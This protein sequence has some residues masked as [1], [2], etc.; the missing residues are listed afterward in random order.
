[1]RS[2]APVASSTNLWQS[3]VRFWPIADISEQLI[4]DVRQ[5][6]NAEAK[7]LL[8]AR[9]SEQKDPAWID[10]TLA[11]L[12]APALAVLAV[13]AE[14]PSILD[15]HELDGWL[16]VRFGLDERER[17]LGIL[18][19]I[20]EVLVV[21]LQTHYSSA[22]ALVTP[23]SEHVV[24]RVLGIDCPPL[25]DAPFEPTPGHDGGRALVATCALLAQVEVRATKDG[26]PHRGGTKRLAKQVAL[27]ESALDRLIIDGLRLGIIEVTDDSVLRVHREALAAAAS[28][29]YPRHALLQG[30][31]TSLRERGPCSANVVDRWA[32]AASV[33]GYAFLEPTMLDRVPGVV[34]GLVGGARAYQVAAPGPNAP[35]VSITPSFEV[36]VPPEAPL[37]DVVKVL[38]VCEPVRLD[39]VIVARLTK[40]SIA[41]A[42]AAGCI[43]VLAV[44]AAVARTPVPQNVAAAVQDWTAGQTTATI[45]HGQV[46]V[47]AAAEEARAAAA[48]SAFRP[49]VLAPGVLVVEAKE[50][51]RAVAAALSK[52]GLVP[53]S[54]LSAR[55]AEKPAQSKE[56]D[57]SSRGAPPL[58]MIAR[59]DLAARVAAYRAGD[60]AERAR[61]PAMKPSGRAAR[62]PARSH[63]GLEDRSFDPAVERMLFAWEDRHELL[64]FEIFD[65]VAECLEALT[66]VDRRFI[67][68]GTTADELVERVAKLAARSAAAKGAASAQLTW[69]RD[70]LLAHL[71]A[72]ARTH[73]SYVF[74]LGGRMQQLKIASVT[75]R[76]NTLMVLG[77]DED[78]RSVAIRFDTIR[79]LAEPAPA[80]PPERAR[81]RPVDGEPP[82][83][84]H[85]WC[86]CGSGERYRSCCR[87]AA[88]PN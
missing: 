30:L 56:G 73:A 37:A 22:Y 16:T 14:Q 41:R 13:L 24:T 52:A 81:W 69:I 46:V 38:S 62:P 50:P 19:T 36:F 44:L 74:D 5:C 28:G 6:S 57:G 4:A 77:E 55:E 66:D 8:A 21:P 59:P 84:G 86:P 67:L 63:N 18:E 72:A 10:A 85:V 1:M 43:D 3:V 34:P 53:R 78:E 35:A 83:A 88:P 54:D 60:R 29:Q 2:E 31:V 58:P 15:Q 17:S 39:R 42:V 61:V 48:L 9:A 49:R 76:G 71:E 11:R 32:S 51:T 68:K 82:P 65:A 12:S 33:R 79:G 87:E 7:Q 47:V 45:A 25:A 80:S 20:R 70:H 23:A 27:D 26:L 75:Y 64:D 40:A